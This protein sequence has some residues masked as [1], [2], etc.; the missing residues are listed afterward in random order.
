MSGSS[1]EIQVYRNGNWSIQAFFDD[2]ELALLEAR[3]MSETNR[4]AAVRVVEEVI[5]SSGNDVKSR[6]V[7][8]HSEVD[9]HNEQARR[10]QQDS[11]EKVVEARRRRQEERQQKKKQSSRPGWLAPNSFFMLALKGVGIA[12]LGGALIY[13]L[14]ALG[15]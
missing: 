15:S 6:V 8:R 7:F 1:Y 14:N 9:K 10:V 5:D 12:V 11:Q 2:K 3:R 13:G 4:Y